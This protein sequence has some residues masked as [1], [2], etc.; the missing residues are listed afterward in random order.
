MDEF[1]ARFHGPMREHWY[2]SDGGHFENLGAYELIRR[3]LPLIVVVDAECDTDY[4]FEGLANLIRKARIDFEAEVEFLDEDELDGVVHD[5]LRS[6]FG[7]LAML[8]R[9]TA[10]KDEA[11]ARARAALARV[12]YEDEAEAGSW[13]LYLKPSLCGDEPAD[14]IK[15]HH[16]HPDFPQETTA[17]QFFDEAQWE[18]YRKLG[19]HMAGRLF[20]KPATAQPDRFAPYDFVPPKLCG[21][22]AR[23]R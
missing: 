19:Q 10:A 7:T 23:D 4:S 13:L 6:Y 17:D 15:Y 16:D 2:L 3:R 22:R 1:I 18:S 11:Y 9:G 21:W 14:L 20:K 8:R 5:E 12:R